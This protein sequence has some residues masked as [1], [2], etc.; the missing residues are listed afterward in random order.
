MTESTPVDAP[1][2]ASVPDDRGPFSRWQPLSTGAQ[3][4]AVWAAVHGIATS[5]AEPFTAA[6][7]SA[8][9]GRAFDAG[10]SIGFGHAGVAM[11]YAQM[12]HATGDDRFARTAVDQ[13]RLAVR[14]TRSQP[15]HPS[16][17]EGPP[18]VSYARAIC[19][20]IL[21]ASFPESRGDETDV[22]IL[23]A[24]R[25]VPARPRLDMMYGVVGL[26]M[27]ALRR[28]PRAPALAAVED[29]VL[30]LAEASV[31]DAVGITWRPL[32]PALTTGHRIFRYHLGM[33]HG[34]AGIV[35]FLARVVSARI[36]QVQAAQL[37]T[38]AVE[39]LL[40]FAAPDG[41]I[42][43]G[44]SAPTELHLPSWCWGDLGITL[45]IA[46]AARALQRGDWHEVALMRARAQARRALSGDLGV[47]NGLCHGRAGIAHMLHR[48][49]YVSHDP[50]FARAARCAIDTILETRQPGAGSGGF[51][52]ALPDTKPREFGRVD[53]LLF[54]SSG[55]GL[56]LLAAVSDST[57]AWDSL[58]MM[59]LVR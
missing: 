4:D 53:G 13:F 49:F 5:L 42:L 38:G 19:R 54:G 32:D 41:S 35:A 36:A 51:L 31:A 22:A 26:G 30:R 37:L 25:N 17:F 7:S 15:A 9:S 29:C 21:P 11:F 27:F 8:S 46:A 48:W 58:L 44:E 34:Q 1:Q 47:D 56:S 39:H 28:L 52:F 10:A 6:R 45:A 12:A 33:A 20:N 18:G 50:L 57:P 3:A 16:L 40:S 59:D 2:S 43:G 55:L 14:A 23:K 24:V